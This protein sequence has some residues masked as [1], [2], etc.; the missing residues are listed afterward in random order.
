VLWAYCAGT[1]G[2]GWGCG[3]GDE[4]PANT[5]RFLG[6]LKICSP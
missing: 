1:M 4:L 5:G 2:T 6:I 3:G